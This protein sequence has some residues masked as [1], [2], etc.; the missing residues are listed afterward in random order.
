M[1]IRDTSPLISKSSCS[2]PTEIGAR[3]SEVIALGKRIVIELGLPETSDTLGRWMAHHV[4]EMI[5]DVQHFE[6]A[7]RTIKEAACA[8]IILKIWQRR[9]EWSGERPLE[10]FEPIFR[11]L[12][13][14][15]PKPASP[16]YFNR[17]RMAM[18]NEPDIASHEKGAP[19]DTNWLEAAST[20]DGTAQALIRYCLMK[21]LE[22]TVQRSEEWL[23]LAK[24]AMNEDD[25]DLQ[26]IELI[27]RAAGLLDA[28]LEVEDER[29]D[30][31]DLS[32]Q[33]EAFARVASELSM[34]LHAKLDEQ[35]KGSSPG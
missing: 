17:V 4:A 16:R 26:A 23:N 24:V 8:E 19:I 22:P 29:R 11:T 2:K 32:E 9:W 33:L 21:A 31:Q 18:R 10:D 1:T 12:E 5:E 13:S 15:D 3:Y 28:D 14:L 6:G 20:L 30:I 7:E 27:F 25:S 34:H 35:G